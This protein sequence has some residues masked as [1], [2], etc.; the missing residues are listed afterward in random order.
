MDENNDDGLVSYYDLLNVA[1]DASQDD[2]REAY[3]RYAQALHPDRQCEDL[4]DEASSYFVQVKDAYEVCAITSGALCTKL[5]GC[6]VY[7]CHIPVAVSQSTP[8]RIGRAL[9]NPHV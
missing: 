5:P 9:H 7:S 3:R 4:R 2:I 6:S 1:K 8:S